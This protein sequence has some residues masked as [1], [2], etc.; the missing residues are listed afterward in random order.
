MRMARLALFDVPGTIDRS[1]IRPLKK[2]PPR[3][4]VT[5]A[6]STKLLPSSAYCTTAWRAAVLLLRLSKLKAKTSKPALL[7]LNWKPRVLSPLPAAGK[8]VMLHDEPVAAGSVE[9]LSLTKLL[10]V[11]PP[12][13]R[14]G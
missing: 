10:V 5:S 2:T 6:A 11:E 4:V 12:I 13:T 1:I 7:M 3:S 8:L 14:A 9:P